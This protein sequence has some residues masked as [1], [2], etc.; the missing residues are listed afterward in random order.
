[1][2]TIHANSQEKLKL[3]K[4]QVLQAYKIEEEKCEP[5]PLFYE[6]VD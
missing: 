4:Q 1:L 2:F 3:A 6:I 5:L